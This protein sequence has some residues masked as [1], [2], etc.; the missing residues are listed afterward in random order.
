LATLGP[1]TDIMRWVWGLAARAAHELGDLAAER[2]LLAPLEPY[3]PGQLGRLLSA[4]RDLCIARLA[5]GSETDAL[6][7]AAIAG[8][9]DRSTP[10]HLAHG[11][12]DHATALTADDRGDEAGPLIDEARRIGEDLGAAQVLERVR[13][14]APESLPTPA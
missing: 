8:L 13:S 1:S 6:F 3:R 10:Y 2:E 11:L 7:G 12:L 4:E 14:A 5:V 9:R